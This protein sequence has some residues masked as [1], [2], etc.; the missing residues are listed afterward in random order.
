[1][2]VDPLYILLMME[3]IVVLAAVLVYVTRRSG[4]QATGAAGAEP[5]AWEEACGTSG[6]VPEAA[7]SNAPAAEDEPAPEG[8]DRTLFLA[9]LE[10][11][12]AE[13]KKPAKLDEGEEKAASQGLLIDQVCDLNLDLLKNLRDALQRGDANPVDALSDALTV[14]FRVSVND[15]LLSFVRALEEQPSAT[16]DTPTDTPADGDSQDS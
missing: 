16:P 3:A 6:A 12:I 10:K 5:A 15:R 2:T 13:L 7:P 1:M 11:N 8:I 14:R 9:M 4:A